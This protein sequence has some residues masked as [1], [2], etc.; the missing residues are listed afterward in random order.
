MFLLYW[1]NK[2]LQN[3]EL[4]I[5]LKKLILFKNHKNRGNIKKT[6]IKNI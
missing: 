4:K 1:K 2:S 3:K 6:K 5:S